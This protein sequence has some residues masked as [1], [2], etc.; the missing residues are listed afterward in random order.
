MTEKEA[1]T[2]R[3]FKEALASKVLK[4]L[5]TGTW[6]AKMDIGVKVLKY[7]NDSVLQLCIHA[8][9]VEVVT[10]GHIVELSSKELVEKAQEV[11]DVVSQYQTNVEQ[12]RLQEV[13]MKTMN[14]LVTDLEP[15]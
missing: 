13:V 10:G 4:L 11:H 3:D 12:L 7:K 6:T 14:K 5:E 1:L 15:M 8:H 2:E 9:S